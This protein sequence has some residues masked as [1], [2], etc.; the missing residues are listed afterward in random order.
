MI[1]SYTLNVEYSG[2]ILFQCDLVPWMV[3]EYVFME[4]ETDSHKAGSYDN[5]PR[6][7]V[8]TIFVVLDLTLD[9]LSYIP[10]NIIS[11]CLSRHYFDISACI[12]L[13]Y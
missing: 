2:G 6:P 5:A 3:A 8:H 1:T 4:T 13:L 12:V 7:L 11:F 9:L 10:K